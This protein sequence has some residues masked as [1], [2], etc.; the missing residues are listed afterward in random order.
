MDLRYFEFD[1]AF[2][3]LKQLI[4]K[5]RKLFDQLLMRTQGDVNEA[6]RWLAALGEQHGLFEHGFTLEDFKQ[7]LE[8]ERSIARDRRTGNYKLT[9]KGE[10]GLQRSSLEAIFQ[11]LRSDV[12]GDHRV[13]AAGIGPERLPET[14]P[15]EFGDPVEGLAVNETLRNALR[16][17]GPGDLSI[18]QED[19]EVYLTD[20]HSS[21]ATVLLIDVSHSM[22]LYGEDRITPA[23]QV[24]LAMTELIQTRYP[25][26]SLDVVL[27]GDEAWR[28]PTDR[29]PYLDCGP[30]HT[31]TRAGLRMARDLLRTRRQAN[32]QIFMITDG[33]PSALTERNGDIYKNPFGLDRRIVNKT[34][35]EADGCRRAGIPITS[36]MLTDDPTLV[37]FIETLTRTNRGR[38]YYASADRV[39]SF[40]LVDYVRNR[41]RRS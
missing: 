26:D 30:F 13:A 17:G 16:R 22:I 20:H 34:L 19:L 6:L 7:L 23:K 38:A 40:V 32:R 3:S 31:N 28:V 29:L 27:F 41:R 1:P 36:F 39:G 4:S 5:L 14:R 11:G 25:K 18:A 2:E 8:K 24:A 33:K 10:R 15:F 35:E 37:D 9:G 21:C 12:A